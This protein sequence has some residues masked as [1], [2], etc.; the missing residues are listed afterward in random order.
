MADE[1]S[2]SLNFSLDRW[3]GQVVLQPSLADLSITMTGNVVSE[4]V[5]QIGT[6]KENLDILS[7]HSTLGWFLILNLDDTNY[8]G[9]GEDADNPFGEAKAGEW[10]AMR[11][12]RTVLN[13]SVKAVGDACWVYF[14]VLED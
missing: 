11:I 3:S 4:G 7:D 6:S 2:L 10:G 12:S 9:Y 13:V 5:Q 8:V 1:L 14:V